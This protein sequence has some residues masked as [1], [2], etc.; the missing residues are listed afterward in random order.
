VGTGRES[1]S[2]HLRKRASRR[3]HDGSKVGHG[4]GLLIDKPR[5]HES[6][7]DNLL[8]CD[9][10]F[11]ASELRPLDKD[12]SA[13]R[14]LDFEKELVQ[15]AFVRWSNQAFIDDRIFDSLSFSATFPSPNESKMETT[16]VGKN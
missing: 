4:Q 14:L 11:W 9:H 8:G 15:A 13:S 16:S 2:L 10:K 7:S 5:D 3:T 1:S 12:V 6:A